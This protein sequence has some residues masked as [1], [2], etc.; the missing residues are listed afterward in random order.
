MVGAKDRK[1][2]NVRCGVPS[3]IQMLAADEKGYIEPDA[4]YSSLKGI[5][6][7]HIWYAPHPFHFD[8]ESRTASVHSLF[9]GRLP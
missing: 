2:A 4:V 6:Y 7:Q 3:D 8:I 1:N 5:I 9:R